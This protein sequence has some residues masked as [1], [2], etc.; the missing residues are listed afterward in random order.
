MAQRQPVRRQFVLLHQVF[1]RRHD[2]IVRRQIQ[3]R[4]AELARPLPGEI[5]FCRIDLDRLEQQ[6]VGIE[7]QAR[8]ISAR[9]AISRI[10]KKSLNCRVVQSRQ[11]SVRLRRAQP[12]GERVRQDRFGLGIADA[13]GQA[14]ER[15]ETVDGDLVAGGDLRSQAGQPERI[16]RAMPEGDDVRAACTSPLESGATSQIETPAF[17]L[18]RCL[19]A[20]RCLLRLKTLRNRR[21]PDFGQR[22]LRVGIRPRRARSWPW[23]RSRRSRTSFPSSG[24]YRR[25]R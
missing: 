5:G 11:R 9:C 16:E 6:H 14:R 18:T 2:R 20:N 21:A 1:E 24:R 4:I 25:G 10:R 15:I 7:P 12:F 13:I 22:H 17:V 8:V 19:H 23:P 3:H